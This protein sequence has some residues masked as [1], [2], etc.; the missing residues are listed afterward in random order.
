MTTPAFYEA[1]RVIPWIGL[2]VLFQGVYLL[3]SI[4][5]NITKQTRYYPVATVAAAAT[6]VGG[7]PAAGPALRRARRGVGQHASPTRVLAFVGVPAVAALLPDGLRV[8]AHR[9][10]RRWPASS[11]YLAALIFVPA[12]APAAGRRCC[13]T[14]ASWSWSTRS[15]CSSLGFY[16]RRGDRRRVA[17]GARGCG[18]GRRRRPSRRAREMAGDV[19]TAVPDET[20]DA[21]RPRRESTARRKATRWTR[22][23]GRLGRE[24]RPSG[25]T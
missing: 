15:C 6:S 5:M 13:C 19:M 9:P 7:Q 14:A 17:P 12:Q 21:P 3:T 22:A 10:R 25:A 4:G 11:A 20:A 8:G 23:S 24:P 18:A 16:Q 2:G 1:A